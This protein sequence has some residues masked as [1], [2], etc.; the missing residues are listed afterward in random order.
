M[1]I[2][3]FTEN[4]VEQRHSNASHSEGGTGTA[5][6]RFV[7]T[8]QLQRGEMR[9]EMH[10]SYLKGDCLDRNRIKSAHHQKLSTARER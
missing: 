6:L 9:G 1:F 3:S 10:D 2:K 5:E 7:K 4:G 8:A